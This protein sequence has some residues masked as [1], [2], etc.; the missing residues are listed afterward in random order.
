MSGATGPRAPGPAEVQSDFKGKVRVRPGPARRPTSA[1]PANLIRVCEFVEP[2]S[3]SPKLQA[4]GFASMQ[5]PSL[6]F[7]STHKG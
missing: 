7:V 3:D 5:A 1:P 2:P 6:I 4:R